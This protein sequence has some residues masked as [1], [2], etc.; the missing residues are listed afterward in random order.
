MFNLFNLKS[1]RGN[2]RRGGR[3]QSADEDEDENKGKAY[4]LGPLIRHR[5]TVK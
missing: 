2:G 1:R 3:R 5:L 4:S